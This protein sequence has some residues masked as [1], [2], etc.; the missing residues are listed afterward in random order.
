MGI[1]RV[2]LLCA[3]V[4]A[5]LTSAAHAAEKVTLLLPAPTSRPAFAPYVV[6]KARG[7]Y[8][9]A[10][11]DVEFQVANGGADV[12]KQVGV[13]NAPVGSAIADTPIIVR[14]NGVMVKTVGVFGGGGLTQLIVKSD[15][16]IK[17][18]ADLKGKTVTV[19]SYQDT[20]Y[21]ALLGMLASVGL[22]KSDVKIL[23]AGPA[24]IWKMF[25][26]DQADAMACVPDYIGILKDA[27]ATFRVIPGDAYFQSMA[28]AIMASDEMI[29]KRPDF[30]RRFVKA[31][32]HGLADIKADPAGA[33]HDF[34]R[35]TPENAGHEASVTEVFLFYTANVFKPQS[36][37]G[38]IDGARMGTL[39][40][41]YAQY[42]IIDTKTPKA[43]LYSNAFVE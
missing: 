2:I 36:P 39:E 29:A 7:Y 3:L 31:T 1:R 33:A 8:A 10:D 6:A 5:T 28:Q 34:V 9:A 13:G 12:A 23:A 26:A 15:S 16:P 24:N 42:G 43:D 32:M 37:L 4:V 40:D 38:A 35:L 11:M 20:T 19:L 14:P 18:P 30:L 17:G 21:Y 25:M 41:F 22:S 27:G